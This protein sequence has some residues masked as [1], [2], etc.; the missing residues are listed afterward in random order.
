MLGGKGYFR[1]SSVLV[2]GTA[3]TGK[4]S[5]ASALVD[6]ACRRGERCLYFSSEESP[7]QI[8]RNM[9]SIGMD[10][11]AWLRQGLLK[12]HATRPTAFGIESHL[13]SFFDHM[14]TFKP[15]VVV[16]DPITN[17]QTSGSSDDVRSMLSRVIDFS[18][19][20]N[21]TLFCTSLTS[22]HDNEGQSEVGISSL[23][24]TWLLL[25][26]LEDAGER[27]RGIYILKSRGMAHSNQIRE[28]VLTNKGIQILDVYTRSGT[29]LMGSARISRIAQDKAA[30][31]AFRN[32]MDRRKIE[33]ARKR[34]LLQSQIAALRADLQLTDGDL[35]NLQT[36]SIVRASTL[37]TL[38]TSLRRSRMGD[39]DSLGR[40]NVIIKEKSNDRKIDSPS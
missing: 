28:F 25:R 22:G 5:L 19:A 38:E 13:V 8:L 4:S 37:S 7:R 39:H 29:V 10:M 9:K 23:M 20:N 2:S 30:E 11:T 17:F 32:D 21:I 15:K 18:K 6:A 16:I 1:G 24:D 35:K 14:T 31:T 12:F 33:I 27:N 40:F 26:N 34:A 36:E 3:G